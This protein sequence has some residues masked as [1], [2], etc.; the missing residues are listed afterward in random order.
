[1]KTQTPQRVVGLRMWHVEKRY[2]KEEWRHHLWLKNLY[3]A[4]S[5]MKYLKSL[6]WWGARIRLKQLKQ[7]NVGAETTP[8]KNL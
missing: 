5:E 4:R 6:G 2:R 7:P 8:D 3:Q 1:M